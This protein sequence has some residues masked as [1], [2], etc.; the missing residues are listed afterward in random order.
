VATAAQLFPVSLE[1]RLQTVLPDGSSYETATRV[2][3]VLGA[4]P[5]GVVVVGTDSHLLLVRLM[6][7]GQPEAPVDLADGRPV[8][9]AALDKTGATVAFVDLEGR[10]HLRAVGS[11][12]DLGAPTALPSSARLLAVDGDRWIGADGGALTVHAPDGP[13]ALRSG[14]P[15]GSAELAG[16]MVAAEGPQ[17]VTFLDAS[18]GARLS[19]AEG[20]VLG[21]LSPDG[22]EYVGARR[23]SFEATGQ[24]LDWYLV[25]T[26]SGRTTTFGGR[27]DRARATAIT[28]QDSDR[29]LVVATD[30][31][32]RGNRIVW[33]CSVAL[34]QCEQ[35]YD[36]PGHTLVVSTR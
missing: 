15:V 26:R 13:L 12:N 23:S 27:P 3:E 29:F 25:G 18:T 34:G 8:Q 31:R 32:Q 17:G 1:G 16:N 2:E 33:D 20:L 14:G 9:R 4:G 21:S 6:R 7:T 5:A 30:A 35:R 22:R 24:S 19:S 36:D 10:V 28:W 11:S